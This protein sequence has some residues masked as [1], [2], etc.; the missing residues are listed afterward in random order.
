MKDI[1]VKGVLQNWR[2]DLDNVQRGA[3]EKISDLAMLQVAQAAA[4]EGWAYA[5]L[6]PTGTKYHTLVVAYQDGGLGKVRLNAYRE[7]PRGATAAP[8]SAAEAERATTGSPGLPVEI[9]AKLTHDANEA[10]AQYSGP[11]HHRT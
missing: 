7:V 8:V 2:A 11:R 3:R 10:S 6:A 9:A 1:F 4:I 5:E